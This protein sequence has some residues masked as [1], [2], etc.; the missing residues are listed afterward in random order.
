MV[1]DFPVPRLHPHPC[2]LPP[3]LLNGL[4]LSRARHSIKVSSL[5]C[6]LLLQRLPVNVFIVVRTVPADQSSGASDG[7][8]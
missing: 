4:R 3:H 1:L 2:L 7:A 5:C 6:T 8:A